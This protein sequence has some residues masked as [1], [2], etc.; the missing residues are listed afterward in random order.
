MFEVVSACYQAAWDDRLWS[1]ALA[2]VCDFME[3]QSGTLEAHSFPD[4]RLIRFYS[5]RIDPD[6][7]ADYAN[8][9]CTINPRHQYLRLTQVGEVGFDRRL[10]SESEMDR[11]EFYC[12]LLRPFGL[13]YF[14]SST[15][16]S[17]GSKVVFFGTHRSPEQGHPDNSL[18][19]RIKLLSPF[20]AQAYELGTRIGGLRAERDD[21]QQ[22]LHA[23]KAGIVLLNDR[24]R[25]RFANRRASRLLD[26][27]P[28]VSVTR[29]ELRFSEPRQQRA[30]GRAL[31]VALDPE[32]PVPAE[33]LLVRRSGAGAELMIDVAPMRAGENIRDGLELSGRR[34][35]ALVVIRS[36][37]YNAA[38]PDRLLCRHYRL[39]RRECAVAR[40]LMDG[41]SLKQI[42]ERD[43]VAI[44]TIR[45][46]YANLRAKLEARN[47]ADVIRRLLPYRGH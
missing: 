16:I 13:R 28:E 9:F 47:Q 17:D 30:F 42:A 43:Q 5:A 10:I 33:R 8:Y 24:G 38:L 39:T 15:F 29:R 26:N 7:A 45:T 3:S 25:I 18:I 21:Y 20:V 41:L 35:S 12:D 23:L 19:R 4:D 34:P 44:T 1:E 37:E 27:H 46:H 6:S 40:A 31:A 36:P 22:A 2:R 11:N 32:S 14:I